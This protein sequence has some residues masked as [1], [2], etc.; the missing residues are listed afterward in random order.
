MDKYAIIISDLSKKYALSKNSKNSLNNN[1]PFFFALKDVNI[2]I[3]KGE[4]IGII[5]ENGS[6]KSTLLKILSQ[7]TDPSGGTAIINGKIAS[8]L[9]IGMGFH[10]ELSGRENIFLSGALL[11][12]RKKQITSVFEKIVEFSEIEPYIDTP[13]KHYSSGMYLRLAFSVVAHLNADILLFDEILS[14]GDFGFQR[15]CISKIKD[16]ILQKK[17]IVLVSHSLNEI[18]KLCDRTILICKG[19]IIADGETNEVIGSYVKNSYLNTLHNRNCNDN[20]LKSDVEINCVDS[21]ILFKNQHIHLLSAEIKAV[22]KDSVSEIS[23]GDEIE[24]T[25][26]YEIQSDS[27]TVIPGISV[28]YIHEMLISRHLAN[29]SAS[30]EEIKLLSVEKKYTVKAFIPANMLNN[31]DY[32][33]DIFFNVLNAEGKIEVISATNLFF[34]I[35]KGKTEYWENFAKESE[36][37][38]KPEIRWKVN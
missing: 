5:G 17:T 13:V 18:I 26:S 12:L 38:L 20:T 25:M 28:F 23:V 31:K 34:K 21:K 22:G 29:K 8:V 37:I 19:E 27:I 1:A 36:A 6:G 7:I 30:L 2:K 10:P 14:V 3:L 35:V 32:V 24:I 4:S 15:K 33:L 11:G 16:L 9:E